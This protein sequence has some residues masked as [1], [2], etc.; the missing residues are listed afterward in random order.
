MGIEIE[1]KFLLVGDAWRSAVSKSVEIVQGYVAQTDTCSVRV[2]IA[3]ER[4]TI[5]F[6]GITIGI[7]RSEFEAEI[8]LTEARQMLQEF[9]EPRI[10]RKIRHLLVHEGHRW[11]IDEF[12]GANQGL[13]VA[14]L[15]LETEHDVFARPDWL[16]EDVTEDPRYYNVQLVENPFGDW[17]RG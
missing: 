12:G 15:E 3:G 5:N 2:R 4:G 7:R 17:S 8:P 9:C 13:I 16:G 6:K 11:E 14:E 10:I 1:R